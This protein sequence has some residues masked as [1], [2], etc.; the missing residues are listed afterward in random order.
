ML[1]EIYLAN[2]D[3]EAFDGKNN[4]KQE[5]DY[6]FR[7]KCFPNE[8]HSEHINKILNSGNGDIPFEFYRGD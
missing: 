6:G 2:C 8:D 1:I 3:V 5:E 7:L 4:T